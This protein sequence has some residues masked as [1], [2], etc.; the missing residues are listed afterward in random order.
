MIN[1]DINRIDEDYII[2]VSNKGLF[3]RAMLN[4]NQ[5]S[6]SS[7][8]ENSFSIEEFTVTF[9]GSLENFSCSCPARGYCKHVIMVFVHLMNLRE[10]KE[11]VSLTIHDFKEISNFTNLDLLKFTSQS[12]INDAILKLKNLTFN[13]SLSSILKVF[14]NE[15]EVVITLPVSLENL[16]SKYDDNISISSILYIQSIF[17]E[18]LIKTEVKLN[19]EDLCHSITFLENILSFGLYNLSSRNAREI[20]LLSI[21]L[22]LSGNTF[23]FKDFQRLKFAFLSYINNEIDINLRDINRKIIS[24][25]DKLYTL[26][27]SAS[28]DI[29]Y[30]LMKNID[31]EEQLD[32]INVYAL[33]YIIIP[34][35]DSKIYC[36]LF[37]MDLDSKKIY[38]L[39]GFS[40][41][42][43]INIK[44]STIFINNTFSAASLLFSTFSLNNITLK[45][46]NKIS[47]SNSLTCT[48]LKSK[49][50]NVDDYSFDFKDVIDSYLDDKSDCF[51]IK[52]EDT[53]NR[54]ILKEEV[55]R[56]EIVI[57]NLTIYFKYDNSDF[58]KN[59]INILKNA[60]DITH[61]LV[62]LEKDNFNI[63]GMLI[64]IW[65]K[66]KQISVGR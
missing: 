30:L 12:K 39:A 41:N 9:N 32:N 21:K 18:P 43:N 47:N 24:L 2:S 11:I 10:N 25:L 8:D 58:S 6:V 1:D 56:M 4:Y 15:T 49:D 42:S 14:V 28:D 48:A 60:T 22:K 59:M 17:G 33:D 13:H 63:E 57:N 55:Q 53:N 35:G 62:K 34:F 20:D 7:L 5:N 3:K 51:I 26:V 52:N 16:F 27:G 40:S 61:L 54:F 36:L 50:F 38:T 45:D 23:I 64:C 37:L 66:G 19:T 46:K 44:S 31:F 65:A 29:K